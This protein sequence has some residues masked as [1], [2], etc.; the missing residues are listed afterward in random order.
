VKVKSFDLKGETT[1]AERF[2]C[3]RCWPH[4]AEAAWDARIHLKPVEFVVDDTHLV[5]RLLV[6]GACGEKFVSIMTETVD[7]V[8]G[9]DPQ[10]WVSIP[11]TADEAA[12]LVAA[13]KDGLPQALGELDHER[14]SLHRDA[15]KGA[16]ATSYWANGI[17]IAQH[18]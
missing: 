9:D 5:V 4:I 13:G 11:L 17:A 6:C 18:D 10:H 16:A 15:P 1:G 3:E 2:G 12:K 7:W 14:R 8:D